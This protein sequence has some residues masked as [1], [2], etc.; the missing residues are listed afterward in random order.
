MGMIRLEHY[1]SQWNHIQPSPKFEVVA[2]GTV[3]PV[4]FPGY[5]LITP[6]GTEDPLNAGFFSQLEEIQRHL[7]DSAQGLP[8]GLAVA[9]PA[10]TFHLTIADLIWEANYRQQIQ[11][12]PDYEVRL[13]NTIADIFSQQPNT[14]KPIGLRVLGFIVMTRAIAVCLAPNTEADYQQILNL[15]RSLYQNSS[16]LALGMDQKYNFTGHITLGYFTQPEGRS[17]DAA[18]FSQYL[19][20]L[21]DT[22]LDDFLEFQLQT[23]ELRK[24][25]NMTQFYRQPSWPTWSF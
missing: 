24:F 1:Q 8:D 10:R 19:D 13:Q 23:V 6:P 2:D 17:R 11:T 3:Q 14:G 7:W 20:R 4:V 16:L 22:F 9:L 5:S 12:T 21:N 25:E 18:Q 15:R